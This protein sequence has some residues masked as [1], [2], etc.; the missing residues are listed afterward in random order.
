MITVLERMGIAFGFGD[1]RV[2]EIAERYGINVHAFV[3]LL[4]SFEGSIKHDT[5]LEK[6]AIPDLLRFLKSSHKH[7]KEQQI[8]HIKKL[9]VLF[10]ESIPPKHAQVIISFFDGY[11]R[12]IE[13]HFH[14]E[15]DDIFPYIT[16]ILTD[17]HPEKFRMSEFEKNHTDIEQKLL[18]LK[19]I[20]IKYIPEDVTSHYRT[21][22][23]KELFE[24][25]RDLTYH[26][27]IE[28]RLLVPSVKKMECIIQSK[29]K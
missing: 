16:D 19:N 26:S 28:D 8:P 22:V 15:D 4:Q 11:I 9:I 12:E 18:D 25:E 13:E 21:E 24:L 7:F 20:L 3:A 5:C 17:P 1:Q 14:Y 6:E 27:F 10:S 2:L 29:T 23:L